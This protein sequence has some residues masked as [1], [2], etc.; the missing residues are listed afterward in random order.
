MAARQAR[1]TFLA[2]FV[3]GLLALLAATVATGSQQDRP[4]GAGLVIRHGDGTLIY[5]YV[6][7]EGETINGEELLARSG[8]AFTVAP[9][10]GF[11]AGICAIDNEGCPA[12]DCW[13]ASYSSPAYYWH[14]FAWNG[15]G[16]GKLPHGASSRELRDG[17]IDGWSW[18]AG[19]AG[20]PAVSIDE[21]ARLNGFERGP[22]PTPISPPTP[23]DT[24]TAT[25][26]PEPSAIATG[27]A[28]QPAA[29]TSTQPATVTTDPPAAQTPSSTLATPTATATS[30]MPDPTATE[31]SRA[32]AQAAS[33]TS[34]ASPT[35][36]RAGSGSGAVIV[37]PSETPEPLV[38]A[39]EQR[40]SDD[41]GNLLLF[42][43]F[44]LA[45]A[46][47]GGLIVLVR[48]RGTS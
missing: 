39:R 11:G 18:T 24:P 23:T 22:P 9:F 40:L 2:G 17:D 32:P 48:M 46:G 43:G 13:C 19:D 6:E 34:E 36:T 16:W 33:A 27:T 38:P 5:A 45:I 30:T 41:R 44:A 3:A 8:L 31:T 37:R 12:D 21:I 35:A 14:Y 42:S 1:I 20:L 15:D 26:P 25:A 4:N 47:I 28:T 29:I 7:F 10:G